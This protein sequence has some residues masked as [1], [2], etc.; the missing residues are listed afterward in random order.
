M[1]NGN[2][3]TLNQRVLGLSPSTPTNVFRGLGDFT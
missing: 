1:P 3:T 2:D